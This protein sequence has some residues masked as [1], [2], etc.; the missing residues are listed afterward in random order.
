VLDTGTGELRFS[1]AGHLPPLLI[2]TEGSVA[3]LDHDP[4]LPVGVSAGD[5]RGEHRVRLPAGAT[6]V[7]YSDGLVEDRRRS[8]EDG[9]IQLARAG[10]LVAADGD[11][12]AT[13]ARI[14]DEMVGDTGGDDDVALLVLRWVGPPKSDRCSAVL[15]PVVA[16]A[17]RA[18]ALVAEE[19]E[20][21]GESE[22]FDTATLCVSEI[23]TNAVVHAGTPVQLDIVLLPERIRVEVVDGGSAPPERIDAQDEDVHGRGIAIVDL[24]SAAWGVEPLDD[25][26]C[27]WFELERAGSRATSAAS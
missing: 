16:S 14:L 17:R 26:K 9:L 10:S 6:L 15:P 19:L 11:V 25:G 23:V 27:V 2:T 24:L 18:R 13:C 22:L 20:R 21:W 7:L 5:A 12:D 1:S 3:F 8:I 4:D